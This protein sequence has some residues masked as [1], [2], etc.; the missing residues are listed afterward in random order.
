M[1]ITAHPEIT[2]LLEAMFKAWNHGDLEAYISFWREDAD[3]VN[4]IGSIFRGAQ[5]S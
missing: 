3:L 2:A 5:Q 1:E 4:I